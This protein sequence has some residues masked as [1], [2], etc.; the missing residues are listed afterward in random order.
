MSKLI[1]RSEHLH[2]GPTL[3]SASLNRQFH[4]LYVCKTVRSITRQCITCRR[5][6][7]R[8]Q[9][10]LMGQLPL[11]CV[12]PGC[13]FEKVGVD[14]AGPFHI[15]Y[16][17]VHKP[18]LV[19]ACVCIFVSLAVKAVHLE[20]VSDLTSDAFI[21]T[22]RRFVA[23]RGHPSLIWSDNGTNFVGANRE[24]KVLYE[25]L[26]H[27]KNQNIISEFCSSRNIEW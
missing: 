22:L 15:K 9:P 27:R 16:G 3:L 14:Y 1:I 21:A 12:T 18:T 11:E 26:A 23:C 10:Q 19:K 17:M 24:L 20:A 7:V 8:P 25:F 13:V 6:A 4:I 5:Q 2:A